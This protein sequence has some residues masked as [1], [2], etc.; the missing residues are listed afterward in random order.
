[1]RLGCADR[2]G[3]A[4]FPLPLH[5]DCHPSSIITR[6]PDHHAPFVYAQCGF[7]IGSSGLGSDHLSPTPM[8]SWYGGCHLDR[9]RT[10]RYESRAERSDPEVGSDTPSVAY[11][12]LR[13]LE[14]NA[15]AVVASQSGGWGDRYGGKCGREGGF[16]RFLF[17]RSSGSIA[18]TL[19][20]RTNVRP[21]GAH[22]PAKSEPDRSGG[23]GSCISGDRPGTADVPP[24]NLRSRI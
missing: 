11:Q 15:M 1:M 17:G 22:R 10:H 14:G 9:L 24:D 8:E 13:N 5:W 2:I 16:R 19:K 18:T 20:L 6:P 12:S 3:S 4:G 7:R 23:R 21:Y